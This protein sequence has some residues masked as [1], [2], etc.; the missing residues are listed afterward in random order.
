MIYD[1]LDNLALYSHLFPDIHNILS[2]ASLEQFHSFGSGRSAIDENL[3]FLKNE[4]ITGGLPKELDGIMENHITHLDV[5][6]VFEGKEII[7]YERLRDH[8]IYKSYDQKGDV[9]LYYAKDPKDII[10]EEGNF[11]IFFPGE[12]HMP[13]RIL[14]EESAMK[15]L[16]F[17]LKLSRTNVTQ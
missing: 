1:S 8:E 3:F 16:V 2:Y 12:I 14:K 17:K 4:Y 6:C 9:E 13:G 5:Q 15:K 11:V 7:Q 10:A